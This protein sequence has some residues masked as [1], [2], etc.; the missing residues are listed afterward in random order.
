MEC[1]EDILDAR[2]NPQL[3]Q[4]GITVN[5]FMSIFLSQRS[6]PISIQGV[7]ELK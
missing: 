5:G 3:M 2:P 7:E 4:T 6:D 1:W